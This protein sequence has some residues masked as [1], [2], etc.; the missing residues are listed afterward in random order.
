MPIPVPPTSVE[1]SAN[2]KAETE[3]ATKGAANTQCGGMALVTLLFHPV[4][5]L[6]AS[7]THPETDG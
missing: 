3:K 7:G 5:L 4:I 6:A 2:A 1:A